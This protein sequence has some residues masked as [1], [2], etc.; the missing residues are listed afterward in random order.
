MTDQPWYDELGPS[1]S[2]IERQLFFLWSK[3]DRPDRPRYPPRDGD[4]RRSGT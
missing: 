2:H 4:P 1:V 3:D